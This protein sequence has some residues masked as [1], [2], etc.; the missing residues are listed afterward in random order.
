MLWLY[1]VNSTLT[2]KRS[3]ALYTRA[4]ALRPRYSLSNTV[5]PWGVHK[6]RRAAVPLVLRLE[7][8]HRKSAESTS[9]TS[10]ILKSPHNNCRRSDSSYSARWC[11]TASWVFS[12]TINSYKCLYW[13]MRSVLDSIDPQPAASRPGTEM[14]F[15]HHSGRV[16]T[17]GHST[18]FASHH[19]IPP[20][21]TPQGGWGLA[22]DHD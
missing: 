4:L 14:P 10:E 17:C 21:V 12:C 2:K 19:W 1:V 9:N 5:R 18:L 7:I 16:K 8:K 20:A 15:G 13:K 11:N 6:Q 22:S 3:T